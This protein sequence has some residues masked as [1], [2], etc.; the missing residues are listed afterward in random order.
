MP[1]T[2]QFG[3]AVRL[4]ILVTLGAAVYIAATLAFARSIVMPMWIGL[5]GADAAP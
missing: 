3:P 1:T 4:L 5:R 2:D